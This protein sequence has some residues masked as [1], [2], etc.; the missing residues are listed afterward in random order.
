[1]DSGGR[2]IQPLAEVAPA[3]A[4]IEIP[5]GGIEI[6]LLKARAAGIIDHMPLQFPGQPLTAGGRR[7]VQRRQPW[8]QIPGG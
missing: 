3:V 5:A 1:M 8:K 7:D 6:E 4:F 2:V